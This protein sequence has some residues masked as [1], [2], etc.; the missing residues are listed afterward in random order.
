MLEVSRERMRARA[1]AV[2]RLFARAFP[3]IGT[4]SASSPGESTAGF[5]G[6]PVSTPECGI[7]GIGSTPIRGNESRAI[8]DRAFLPNVHYFLCF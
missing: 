1:T 5:P 8:A 2:P 6:Y 4:S 3:D 7:S